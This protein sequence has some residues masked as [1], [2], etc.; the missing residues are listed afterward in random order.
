MFLVHIQEESSKI[1]SDDGSFRDDLFFSCDMQ[2]I[3]DNKRF[4]SILNQIY[5]IVFVK[6]V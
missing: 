2:L 1:C 3:R 6:L 4:I 5:V